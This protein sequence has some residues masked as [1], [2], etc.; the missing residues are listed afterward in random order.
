MVT[1]TSPWVQPGEAGN[2]LIV[3]EY[4]FFIMDG[5]IVGWTLILVA[6]KYDVQEGHKLGAPNI[7]TL[8]VNI[9]TVGSRTSVVGMCRTPGSTPAEDLE[10]FHF[11]S[12]V[13][14]SVGQLL[15]LG[16]FNA[17]KIDWVY[18]TAPEDTFGHQLLK[19][20]RS[21]GMIQQ[22]TQATRWILG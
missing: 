18:K 5:R 14:G 12:V 13:V 3:R 17:P 22:V 1:V 7:Q 6:E 15:I 9:T 19:F 20:V 16:D 8:E 2:E 10:R 11:L 4:S 21:S